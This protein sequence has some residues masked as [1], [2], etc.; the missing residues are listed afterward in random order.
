MTRHRALTSTFKSVI[1]LLTALV[2]AVLGASA[3]PAA[4]LAGQAGQAKG[5]QSDRPG[6]GADRTHK[7]TQQSGKAHKA[8]KATHKSERPQKSQGADR[9]NGHASEARGH[10]KST[11]PG[12]NGAHGNSAAAHESHGKGGGKSETAHQGGKGDKGDPP[13]NN[14]TVKIAPLGEND[15]TPDNNPHVGCSFQIEWYGFDEGS[16]IWSTVQFAMQAPTSDVGLSGTSPEK[17][18]VG[19]DPATGAGTE[20]GLDGV[21]DY[22]LSFDGAPH[23]QQGYH[24]KLTVHTPYSKGADTK[25]KVFWVEPCE[26]AAPPVDTPDKADNPD[27]PDDNNHPDDNN[28]PDENNGVQDEVDDNGNTPTQVLGV[29]ASTNN[30]QGAESAAAASAGGASAEVP[31]AVDSGLTGE[32]WSRSVLPVL[33][34]LLG[35]GTTFVALVRRRTRVEAVSRD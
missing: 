9:R 24:V 5:H 13:G 22:T 31:T 28:N 3:L 30:S 25:H 32:Q 15:G 1:A 35:L 7:S 19:G 26:Q 2:V 21:Q 6:N 16:D 34:V 14:G 17:V 27:N 20:S 12:N 18:F 8:R 4:A 10:E 23:P 11:Q 29:Q 33:V